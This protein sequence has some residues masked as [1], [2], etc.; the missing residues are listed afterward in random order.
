M[1]NNAK[2]APSEAAGSIT[3]DY[4]MSGFPARDIKGL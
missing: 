4:E 2:E 3:S 1:R